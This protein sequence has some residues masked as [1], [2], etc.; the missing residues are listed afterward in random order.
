MHYRPCSH[1][2]TQPY[3]DNSPA[4]EILIFKS[5][6]VRLCCSWFIDADL[7][8]PRRSDALRASPPSA[9][10]VTC[11][12]HAT[13]VGWEWEDPSNI[14]TWQSSPKNTPRL[15]LHTFFFFYMNDFCLLLLLLLL[16]HPSHTSSK[17][18][19]TVCTHVHITSQVCVCLSGFQRGVAVLGGELRRDFRRTVIFTLR[20][21]FVRFLSPLPLRAKTLYTLGKL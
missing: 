8:S 18:D 20:G 15:L 1:T 6:L 3:R 17:S 12:H 4:V 9:A 7:M 14:T 5:S 2:Y 21:P 19:A 16:L 10:Q 13:H 11:W